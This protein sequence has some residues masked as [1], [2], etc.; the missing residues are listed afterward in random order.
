MKSELIISE[1][2]RPMWQT[3]VAAFLYT[4]TLALIFISFYNTKWE[5][6]SLLYSAKKM[7]GVIL[8]LIAAV[9]F[10]SIKKVYVDL[11]NSKFRSTFE[12]LFIKFGKWKTINNYEYVSVFHQ[13]LKGGNYIYEVNLWYDRNKHL[14]LYEQY[15]YTEAFKIGYLLSEKLKIDLL[16]ATV[17]N[18]YKWVDKDDWGKTLKNK[19]KENS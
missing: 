13:P 3:I 5:Y 9:S 19:S 16:D 4:A 2:N 15:N 11:E 10:S 1:A 17:P 6:N 7:K 14:K 12:V 18:D 8:V